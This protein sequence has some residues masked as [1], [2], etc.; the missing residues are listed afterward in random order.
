M[1]VTTMPKLSLLYIREIE[2]ELRNAFGEFEWVVLLW[3]KG[4]FGTCVRQMHEFA[5]RLRA[6]ARMLEGVEVL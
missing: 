1:E 6:I 5:R 4:G 2:H 3:H